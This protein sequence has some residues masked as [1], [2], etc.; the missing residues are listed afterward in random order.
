MIYI[1][2]SLGTVFLNNSLSTIHK[3]FP[4]RE[5][6]GCQVVLEEMAIETDPVYTL[7][8]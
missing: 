7:V 6:F 2:G 5:E 4:W 3:V 1:M 8:S